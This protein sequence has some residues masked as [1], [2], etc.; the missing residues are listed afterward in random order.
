MSGGR[1]H[2]FGIGTEFMKP[3]ECGKGRS[4]AFGRFRNGQSSLKAVA[5]EGVV[6]RTRADEL[7]ATTTYDILTST[8]STLEPPAGSSRR[9]VDRHTEGEA[10][11]RRNY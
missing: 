7:A 8:L 6:A 3:K 2:V 11:C 5:L 1:H 9:L 4:Y 10:P